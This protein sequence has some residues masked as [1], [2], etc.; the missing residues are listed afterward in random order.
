MKLI[1]SILR[2]LCTSLLGGRY[3]SVGKATRY[4]LNGLEVEHR[5]WVDVPDRSKP[6]RVSLSVFYKLVPGLYPWSKAVGAWRRTP[7]PSSMGLLP[8]SAYMARNGTAFTLTNAK[9]VLSR[10]IPQHKQHMYINVLAQKPKKS[11]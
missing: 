5:W 3:N 9:V 6:A 7:T 8:F 4:G 2:L 11:I 10:M 1:T